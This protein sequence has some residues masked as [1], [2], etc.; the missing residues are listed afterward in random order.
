MGAQRHLRGQLDRG[1]A[2]QSLTLLA[3]AVAVLAEKAIMQRKSAAGGVPLEVLT[4]LAGQLS[5]QLPSAEVVEA[6]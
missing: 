4:S 1:F 5:A 6:S 2:G 3:C